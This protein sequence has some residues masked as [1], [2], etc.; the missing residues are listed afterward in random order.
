MNTHWAKV[1]LEINLIT[2]PTSGPPN[3]TVSNPV[4]DYSTIAAEIGNSWFAISGYAGVSSYICG[5]PVSIPAGDGAS[6]FLYNEDNGYYS[7]VTWA[8]EVYAQ[9]ISA[10]AV[11][12]SDNLITLSSLSQ[13]LN[14]QITNVI[15][16]GSAQRS[17]EQIVV[18]PVSGENI[19]TVPTGVRRGDGCYYELGDELLRRLGLVSPD[20]VR[21]YRLQRRS[22]QR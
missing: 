19:L 21:R 12:L 14:N 4:D 1:G 13:G 9:T 17:Y 5:T 3:L 6:V 11:A 10:A 8:P 15:Y 20:I 2:Y 22:R 16:N 7:Y 18:S